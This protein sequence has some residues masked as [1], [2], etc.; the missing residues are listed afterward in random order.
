V[1]K[2]S[3]VKKKGPSP[4]PPRKPASKGQPALG[5]CTLTGSGPDVQYEG[6]TQQECNRRAIAAGKNPHWVKGKCAQP[7]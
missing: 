3:K 1:K 2:Q 4:S 6:I 5:C 7:D